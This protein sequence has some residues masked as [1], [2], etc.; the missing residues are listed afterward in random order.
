MH[1]YLNLS[2]SQLKENILSF[3]EMP[4]VIFV[5]LANLLLFFLNSLVILNKEIMARITY[6]IT[7][8]FL[9]LLF[10]NT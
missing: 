5:M 7:I 10:K 8:Y 4:F 9:F 3:S 2:M 1:Y 6:K